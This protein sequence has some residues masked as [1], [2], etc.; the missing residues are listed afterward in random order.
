[1][2]LRMGVKKRCESCYICVEYFEDDNTLYCGDGDCTK[3]EFDK[4]ICP[5][6]KKPHLMVVY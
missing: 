3:E 2:K 6:C 5:I 1:M 4:N